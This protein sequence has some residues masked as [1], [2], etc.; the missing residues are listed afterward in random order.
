MPNLKITIEVTIE[1]KLEQVWNLWNEP[2]HIMKWN[3]A[4][5]DWHTVRAENELRVGGKYFY[6][7]EAKD[8]SIGFDCDAVYIEVLLM[9]KLEYIGF[10]DRTVTIHF[11][12]QGE[13]TR[14]IETFDIENENPVELQKTGWQAILNNFRK[15]AESV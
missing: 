5:E 13:K 9:K 2:E 7:M 6:R 10:G 3:H 4:S 11:Q 14:I 8:G 15:Y 12:A 1:K